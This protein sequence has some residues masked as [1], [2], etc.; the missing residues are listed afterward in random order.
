MQYNR[1]LV[2]AIIL[3]SL[4]FPGVCC[5]Q[6][7]APAALAQAPAAQAQAPATQAQTPAAQ[8]QTPAAQAQAPATQAQAPAAQAQAPATL[9]PR[10]LDAKAF[11]KE[12]R[13]RKIAI[14]HLYNYTWQALAAERRA[15]C[16][17]AYN[18]ASYIIPSRIKNGGFVKRNGLLYEDEY[19]KLKDNTRE[20]VAKPVAIIFD[21]DETI[22]DSSDLSLWM[23]Q[24]ADTGYKASVSA[25]FHYIVL[26][27]EAR[28]YVPGSIEFIKQCYEWGITPIFLT[29]RNMAKRA[30]TVAMLKDMFPHDTD[31]ESR[32]INKNPEADHELGVKLLRELHV[33]DGDKLQQ[34]VLNST[35]SKT[36]N[37]LD[38]EFKYRVIGYFGDDL[39]DFPVYVPNNLDGA[40]TRT[41]RDEQVD[42]YSHHFGLEWFVTPN[43]NYG[44]WCEQ[45]G[46]SNFDPR[47]VLKAI[48]T[49]DVRKFDTWYQQYREQQDK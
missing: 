42:T 34:A 5:A 4:T 35:S 36:S 45:S 2:N 18:T 9:A 28:K 19:I 44:S 13:E 41:A 49:E 30:D 47:T 29:G 3:A 20:R 38:L 24:H 33:K 16:Y 43:A 6:S 22:I 26:H 23:C 17:Q 37:R 12:A 31:I 11:V 27:P 21:I 46:I 32:I 40:D 15:L 39:N 48:D 14:T 10:A 7:A 8:A 25:Y 1:A